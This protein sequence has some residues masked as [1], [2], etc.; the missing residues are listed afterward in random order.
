M[1]AQRLLQR[2]DRIAECRAAVAAGLFW[3][4]VD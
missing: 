2:F 3:I 4:Y 1:N